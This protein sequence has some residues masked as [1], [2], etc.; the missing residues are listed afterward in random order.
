M[1][2]DINIGAALKYWRDIFGGTAVENENTVS[3]STTVTNAINGNGDR[4]GLLIMNL[5]SA[6]V[7]V[8]IS[9]GI[10]ANFG[11]LLGA[12]GG[13]ISLNVRDDF[14]LQTR[15]WSAIC[16]SGGPSIIYTL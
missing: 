11:T 13:F 1:K 10:S 16:P 4:L 6:N 8:G 12:N 15:N 2:N 9:S 14:T 5:G 7:F 3:V